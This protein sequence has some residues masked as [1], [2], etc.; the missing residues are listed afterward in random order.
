MAQNITKSDLV[1]L[2][3]NTNAVE[4]TI[5]QRGECKMNKT[6][7]PFFHREGGEGEQDHL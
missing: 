2:L 7:N 3:A 1:K 4:I 6:N 5:V